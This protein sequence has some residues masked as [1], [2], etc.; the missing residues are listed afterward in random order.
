MTTEKPKYLFTITTFDADPD[1]VATP[2]VLA[3]SA[4]A[5]GAD[6]LLWLSLEGVNLGKKGAADHLTPR[7]FLPVADLLTNY[8]ESGGRIGVCPPCAKTHGVTDE[9]RVATSEWMGATAVLAAG[10][11]RQAFSF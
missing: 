5:G 4:L 7:S 3:N 10:Q 1:R 9:N 6:V 8:L 2:L 11:G